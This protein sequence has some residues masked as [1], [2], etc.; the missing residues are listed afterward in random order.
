MITN[1]DVRSNG[2]GRPKLDA[3]KKRSKSSTERYRSDF[4]ILEKQNKRPYKCGSCGGQGHRANNC[5]PVQLQAA[6]QH[7]MPDPPSIVKK[8][9]RKTLKKTSKFIQSKQTVNRANQ[10]PRPQQLANEEISLDDKSK[11]DNPV[12]SPSIFD[13]SDSSLVNHLEFNSD[14]ESDIDERKCPLCDELLPE[15]PSKKFE[16]LLRFHLAKPHAKKRPLPGNPDAVD[17]P[18][19]ANSYCSTLLFD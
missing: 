3:Q 12:P 15:R 4:E 10:C 7:L 14:D 18:V 9:P 11:Q 6:A 1:P 2:R 19:S 13:L 5:T 16:E 17:L 8:T